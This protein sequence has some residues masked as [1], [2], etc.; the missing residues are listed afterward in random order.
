MG[1]FFSLFF[2]VR[3]PHFPHFQKKKTDRKN[4]PRQEKHFIERKKGDD[5]GSS[6]FILL[7]LIII[8]FSVMASPSASSF[9]WE[10]TNGQGGGAGYKV[11]FTGLF[12]FNEIFF[13]FICYLIA[14]GRFPESPWVSLC[15][16]VCVRIF[17]FFFYP[18][19]LATFFR[20][21]KETRDRKSKKKKRKK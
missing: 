21:T 11:A 6:S 7:L 9:H 1:R 20:R 12:F 17:F 3:F 8:F 18:Q 19:N 14:E 15:V 2:W 16:C 10:K 4:G 13:Y 5:G